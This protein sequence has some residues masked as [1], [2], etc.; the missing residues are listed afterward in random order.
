MSSNSFVAEPS[1]P[2]PKGLQET[3]TAKQVAA[4]LGIN[5]STIYRYVEEGKFPKP[6][7]L[8]AR[9]QVFIKEQV[10]QWFI[11]RQKTDNELPTIPAVVPEV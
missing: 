7:K 11:D 3:I 8:S 10:I 9:R 1:V 5:R 6:V 2:L 4:W